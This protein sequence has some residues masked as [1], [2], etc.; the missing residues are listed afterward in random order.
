MGVK[1]Y[2]IVFV[3]NILENFVIQ[4]Q[5]FA[6][7]SLKN[8][9]TVFANIVEPIG[10]LEADRNFT[11]SINIENAGYEKKQINNITK[12]I[13]MKKEELSDLGVEI[14]KEIQVNLGSFKI[15]IEDGL[16]PN[17]AFNGNQKQIE[18]VNF[19]NPSQTITLKLDSSNINSADS[20]L[21]KIPVSG[22]LTVGSDVSNGLF[23]GECEISVVL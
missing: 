10:V 6:F 19:K 15:S 2:K 22:K 9:G 18:L 12:I 14:P 11:T 1:I 7:T 20:K 17:I 13:K 8:T 21:I 5:C 3:A 4:S 23:S 16:S